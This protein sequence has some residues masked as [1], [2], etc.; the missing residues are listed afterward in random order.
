MKCSKC[1]SENIRISVEV[2]MYIDPNDYGKLT[3]KA[4]AKKTTEILSV[5]DN[6]TT[7]VCKDCCYS[8][9]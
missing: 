3:K 7:I 9:R 1:G 5:N 2:G 8:S 4:I 6:R